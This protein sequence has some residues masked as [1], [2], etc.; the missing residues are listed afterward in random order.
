MVIRVVGP[1]GREYSLIVCGPRSGIE[2]SDSLQGK[3][4]PPKL[5]VG[6]EGSG[7]VITLDKWTELD[8]SFSNRE[9]V[10]ESPSPDD[11]AVADLLDNTAQCLALNTAL[12]GGVIKQINDAS[13]G[14]L[15]L[16]EIDDWD[17]DNATTPKAAD[18]SG[19]DDIYSYEEISSKQFP[20]L[21]ESSSVETVSQATVMI[22]NDAWAAKNPDIYRRLRGVVSREPN[23]VK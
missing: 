7:F 13:N 12:S 6:K 16:I 20:G 2:D 22:A 5:I 21:I 1:V 17:L 18:G 14:Q 9:L 15:H 11:G 3:S 4:P 23:L 10:Y 19:G 8:S